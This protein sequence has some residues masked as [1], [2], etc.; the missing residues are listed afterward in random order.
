MEELHIFQVELISLSKDFHKC[1]VYV[2]DIVRQSK[3]TRVEV[4]FETIGNE[5]SD[6]RK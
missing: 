3:V 5:I 4:L 1:Y 6:M 2:L